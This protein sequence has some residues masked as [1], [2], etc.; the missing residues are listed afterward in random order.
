MS[1]KRWYVWNGVKNRFVPA[2]RPPQDPKIAKAMQRLKIRLATTNDRQKLFNFRREAIETEPE[3]WLP[4]ELDLNKI[5]K[6]I[7]EWEPSEYPNNFIIVAELNGKIIGF[8]HLT[9]CYRL[10][11]GGPSA[12]VEDLFVLKNFRGYKVGTKLMEF[13]KEIAREKGCK[14]LKLIVGLENLA[15][16]RFYRQCGFKTI[17]VGLATMKLKTQ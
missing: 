12:W 9:I 1:T 6:N 10:F 13:A 7:N 17:K 2:K 14:T 8:L 4:D 11:N 3:I 5:R 16:L 15:G